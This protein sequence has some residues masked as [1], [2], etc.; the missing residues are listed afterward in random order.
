MRMIVA[1][2]VLM[3]AANG[4]LAEDPGFPAPTGD[5]SIV[6][7]GERLE[8]LYKV[9]CGI[10]E[11]AS[12]AP[13]GSIYFSELTFSAFCKGFDGKYS[14]AGSIWKYDPKTGKTTL[15]RSPSGQANGIKFDAEGNMLVAEMADF[16]GQRISITDAKTGRAYTMA[17]L[18]NGRTF[19]APNDITIAN[20]GT[21]Y[22]TDSRYLGHEP[23]EQ[24]G[25][26]VYSVSAEGRI[27][28][29]SLAVGTANG[30]AISPDQKRLYVGSFANGSL[31]FQAVET[32]KEH[33]AEP[34]Y[35]PGIG[36]NKVWVFDILKDGSLGKRRV[37]VD[38]EGGG[39]DGMNVDT[40]GNL[41]V[42]VRNPKDQAFHVYSPE[43]KLLAKIPV[44]ETNGLPTNVGWGRGKDRGTLY[45]TAGQSLYRLKTNAVGHQVT[46]TQIV[47]Q[48]LQKPGG[49]NVETLQKIAA[50]KG[51]R[52]GAGNTRFDIR[53][54]H[55][56]QV[57]GQGPVAHA[58][59]VGRR[60]DADALRR[61][62][63]QTGRRA[64]RRNV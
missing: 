9:D 50:F 31:E 10:T 25:P 59:A 28:R 2:C 60:D 37:F 35:D 53:V 8:R 34:A 33:L 41:Y 62:V 17:G 24:P 52:R 57:P 26:A 64:D 47:R 19:M 39:P 29:L 6:I 16:G 1:T 30:V 40:N 58:G 61:S 55:R 14:E 23:V 44:Q 63:L 21:V 22:F 11:G 36:L 48:V 18:Y 54:K 12:S 51:W 15:F 5:P 56:G 32:E 3:L 43:A 49:K 20:D 45:L 13:D 42:A 27:Q 4:A 38:L 46:S 7:K